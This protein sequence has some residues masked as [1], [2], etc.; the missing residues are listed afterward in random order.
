[1]SSDHIRVGATVD[2]ADPVTEAGLRGTTVVQIALGDLQSHGGPEITYPGGAEAL[3]VT[4]QAAGVDI[5][6]HAPYVINV[7]STNNRVRIP[8]RKL[9]AKHMAAAAAIGAKGLIVHGGH[10]SKDEDPAI[11]FDNWRKAVDQTDLTVPLLIENTAG[12]ANAVARHTD[13]IGRLWEALSAAEGFENVGLCLDT[14]HAWAGGIPLPTAVETLRII[15]GRI[16]LV[17]GND[18]RDDFGSGADRHA[19]LGQGRIDPDELVG[20]IAAARA[21]VVLE[22]PGGVQEHRE[23][24]A[25]LRERLDAV[26]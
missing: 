21:P 9:L 14:C 13:R 2:Q 12:G 10:L 18:S 17:H 19:N 23:D 22:T 26:H 24:I 6:V 4:A 3:R 5:Y 20:V 7:A 11:G 15:T 25:W 1:M 8:S 16:D